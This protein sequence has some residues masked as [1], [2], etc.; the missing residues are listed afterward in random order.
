MDPLMGEVRA[1]F[2]EKVG[3]VG[4]DRARFPELDPAKLAL[5]IYD[6]GAEQVVFA[7]PRRWKLHVTDDGRIAFFRTKKET[8]DPEAFIL[9]DPSPRVAP[10]YRDFIGGLVEQDCRKYVARN[11]PST[12]HPEGSDYEYCACTKRFRLMVE[13]VGEQVGIEKLT[14]RR[15]RYTFGARIYE[16]T[17]DI[18]A[19][20]DKLG[21]G[22]AAALTYTRFCGDDKLV[23]EAMKNG[24]F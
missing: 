19:V 2:V 21:C 23:D 22:L 16:K 12:R 5:M 15:L 1:R 11:D 9:L 18:H 24:S 8:S 13:W 4:W 6:T 14:P 3:S 17:R 20:M 10:F 7:H